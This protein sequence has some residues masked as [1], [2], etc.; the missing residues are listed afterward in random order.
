MRAVKSKKSVYWPAALLSAGVLAAGCGGGGN[1][2]SQGTA[3]TTTAPAA[4]TTVTTSATSAP[5]ATSGAN[6]GTSSGSTT[7]APTTAPSTSAPGTSAPS[8]SG[9]TTTAVPENTV[10]GSQPAGGPVPSGFDPVSFTAISAGQYWLLG[11]A[12]CSNP[13]CT[14]IVR[15]TDG[16]SRF[17]GLPAPTAP[18]ATTGSGINTL[19][20]ADTLDG[21][22]FASGPGGE[23]WDTHDGGEQWAQQGFLSGRELLAFGTG[24]GYV[25][26][27]VGSCQQGSCSSVVLD[28]SPVGSDQWS[29]LTVPGVSGGIDQLA[30]MT[31]HGT[32]LWFSLTSSLNQAH[33]VLVAATGSGGSF[34]TYAS[35]CFS[36]LGGNI[37]AS[38]SGVL[39][40]VCPTGME[41]QA[42]R[43]TDGGA[44]WSTLNVGEL[45]NS[46][47]L[48]PASDTS[49]VLEPSAQ[50]QFL[51]TD[52]GGASWQSVYPSSSGSF[53]WS[54]AGFTDSNTGSA[55]RTESNPPP[56]WPF[57]NGPSPQQL[58]RS[59]D[60]GMT[61]SGPVVIG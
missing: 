25:F 48:A 12:P 11:D 60:G 45:E 27:L 10:A 20:F 2:A 19:R 58:W 29:A 3:P 40:A 22:A 8:T 51:R 56:G 47:L 26:A 1:N 36:G 28:R 38:S 42:F 37:Q 53:W 13:V 23:F 43:S 9:P 7:A 34:A 57:P 16:G 50:G 41:A 32:N 5:P 14:S 24:G 21:Y 33:Q 15:T 39:W 30:T 59:S 52:D 4:A 35:P 44:K 55:L 18:I 61:W 17:V 49:A 6:T 46:A 31:V 54:W